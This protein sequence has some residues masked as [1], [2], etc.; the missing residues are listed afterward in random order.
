MSKPSTST[1]QDPAAAAAAA[2]SKLWPSTILLLRLVTFLF[3]FVSIVVLATDSVTLTLNLRTVHVR[4]NDIYAYRYL[5]S[6]AVIGCAYTLLQIPFAVYFVSV[7]KRMGGPRLQG[8]LHFDLLADKVVALVLA[9]GA[10]AGFGATGDFKKILDSVV[11]LLDDYGQFSTAESLSK[12]DKFF[13]LV[14]VSTSFVLIACFAMTILSVIS[15]YALV[16]RGA[17]T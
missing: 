7:G 6:A 1:D 15:T 5:L 10:G 17:S 3:L 2:S 8:L 11:D 9:T 14:H 12:L 13:S 4:F 16:N